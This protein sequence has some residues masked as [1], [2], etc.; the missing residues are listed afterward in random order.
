M[1]YIPSELRQLILE[2]SGGCCEYCRLPQSSST[3]TF[4]MEHIIAQSHGG[5]TDEHNLAL[6]C[7]ICNHYKGPNIAAADPD[8]GAPTFLFHPRR[9]RWDEHFSLK[10]AMIESQ[11]PE[12]RATAFVL[13]FNE[14]SRLKQRDV[15]IALGSYPCK[16][17]WE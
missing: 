12:G 2:R 7:P 1:T 8:T 3:L 6:S 11:T 10:G 15:L 17:D 13:H 14:Q 5:L 4:H 16:K 9:D